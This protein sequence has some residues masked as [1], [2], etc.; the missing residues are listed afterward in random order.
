MG[1]SYVSRAMGFGIDDVESEGSE[2]GESETF[3]KRHLDSPQPN[4]LNAMSLRAS[5][6]S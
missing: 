1:S 3:G 5:A 4:R 2:T 6:G